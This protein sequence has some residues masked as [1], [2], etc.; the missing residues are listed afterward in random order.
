[1]TTNYYQKYK[2]R[3]PKEAR[4]RYQNLSEKEKDKRQKEGW[5]QI[6]N[7][8]WKTKAETTW[9]YEKTLFST[10]KLLGYFKDPRAIKFVSWISPWNTKKLW[11]FLWVT[12]KKIF[13]L[14]FDYPRL[15]HF[16]LLRLSLSLIP[17]Q[18]Y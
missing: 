17:C 13:N 10:E 12:T 6:S 11:I 2:E 9:V 3:I 8:Y 15:P 14:F 4:E 5:R 7:S 16:L 1:M 18:F